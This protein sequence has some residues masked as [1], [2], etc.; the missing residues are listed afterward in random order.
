[1]AYSC[2]MYDAIT[3]ST[4]AYAAVLFAVLFAPQ[5]GLSHHD[6]GGAFLSLLPSA[7]SLLGMFAIVFVS[8][9]HAMAGHPDAPFARGF[10]RGAAV[11]CFGAILYAIGVAVIGPAI[12]S[13]LAFTWTVVVLSAV[14]VAALGTGA[15]ALFA[16]LSLRSAAT[17]GRVA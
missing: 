11:S 17:S 16:Y 7:V 10:A 13:D 1:M 8:V 4:F 3:R 12:F 9:R 6:A 15:S 5:V 2:A 14:A